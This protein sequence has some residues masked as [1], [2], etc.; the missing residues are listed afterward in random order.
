MKHGSRETPAHY[1]RI[2]VNIP[3]FSSN[4]SIIALPHETD[5][6]SPRRE[7]PSRRLPLPGIGVHLPSQPQRRPGIALSQTRA[8]PPQPP[9][10]SQPPWRRCGAQTWTQHTDTDT[11]VYWSTAGGEYHYAMCAKCT[12]A[13]DAPST[14]EQSRN[15][16]GRGRRPCDS[17]SGFAK[18]L[19]Y[20]LMRSSPWTP[21]HSSTVEHQ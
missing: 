8:G 15:T 4:R 16:A 7:S 6:P 10:F 9:T 20:L 17:V 5:A 14:P 19:C 18:R 11:S 21:L 3:I 1:L 13:L 12:A 2:T